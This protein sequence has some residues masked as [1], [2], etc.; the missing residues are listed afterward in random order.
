[1]RS[2]PTIAIGIFVMVLG[3][4]GLFSSTGSLPGL[5]FVGILLFAVGEM[6]C[7]PRFEQYLI[8]LL[9]PEKT[10]LGGGLLR[11]P[12]AIGAFSGLILTPVYGAFEKAGRPEAI[13]LVVG[14]TLL[15]GFLAV[16]L[17]D[18]A[19]RSAD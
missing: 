7:M 10:G 14:G 17:Y 11:I 9:P 13:W 8:S 15:V 19:F 12:V 3:C 4:V 16:V 6:T 18:R 5:M 2:V 1:M